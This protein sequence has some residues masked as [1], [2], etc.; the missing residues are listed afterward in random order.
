MLSGKSRGGSS[1]GTGGVNASNGQAYRENIGKRGFDVVLAMSDPL[2]LILSEG[3]PGNE[4][5]IRRS[6]TA[7]KWQFE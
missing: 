1:S 2:A 5:T 4:D 7:F 3:K 6:I